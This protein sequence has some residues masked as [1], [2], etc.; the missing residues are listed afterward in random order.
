MTVYVEKCQK[1]QRAQYETCSVND[2]K[3]I[4]HGRSDGMEQLYCA[5]MVQKKDDVSPD[6]VE[7]LAESVYL[8]K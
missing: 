4:R 5:H 2:E 8:R 3:A 6:D 7:Q 1:Q